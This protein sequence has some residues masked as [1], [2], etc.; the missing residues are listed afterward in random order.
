MQEGEQTKIKVKVLL[1]LHGLVT[2]ES[3][4][5]IVEEDVEEAAPKAGDTPMQVSNTIAPLHFRNC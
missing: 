1:N 5:Q 4:H 3:A 2:V